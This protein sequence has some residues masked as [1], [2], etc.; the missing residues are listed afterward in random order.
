[1]EVTQYLLVLC[2][3][4]FISLEALMFH[5]SPN[6]KKCLKEEIHKDV[7]VTGEFEISDAG[8]Q[9]KA[10]LMVCILLISERCSLF[11]LPQGRAI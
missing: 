2:S 3:L 5:L 11:G 6:Q 7:L 1:M 4:C 9:Q 8:G 10:R